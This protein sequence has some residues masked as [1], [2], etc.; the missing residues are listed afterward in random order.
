MQYSGFE[1]GNGVEMGIIY[2]RVLVSEE[3][4]LHAGYVSIIFV[5]I[6]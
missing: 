5:A 6:R 2:C 3:T 4:I 1:I